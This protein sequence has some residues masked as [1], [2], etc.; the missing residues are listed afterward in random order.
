MIMRIPEIKNPND[1]NEVE[2]LLTTLMRSFPEFRSDYSK[3]VKNIDIKISEL[4]KIDIHLRRQPESIEFNRNRRHKL[5]EINNAIRMF[6]K[7]HLLASL[8]KR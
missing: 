6:S 7:M 5:R 3:F 4:A 2:K 8:S 1:W